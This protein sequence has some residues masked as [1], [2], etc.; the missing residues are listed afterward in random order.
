MPFR[1]TDNCPTTK[2]RL[3]QLKTLHGKIG[4]PIFFPV[5]SQATVKSLSPQELNEIGIEAI[6]CNT[7]HLY[8]RPGIDVIEKAG[9]LHRFMGWEKPILTDSGGY[10][11]FSLA[12][13][14]QI[15]SNGV[16]FRS[17]IDGS[18]HYITPEYAIQLQEKLGADIIMALD[19]CPSSTGK[20]GDLSRA[21]EI[22]TEWA[23]RC[24]RVHGNTG[25]HLFG[26]VQGGV[27]KSLRKTSAEALANFGF[28]GYAIGGLSL[29]EKKSEMWKTVV[30]TVPFLPPDK[31]RYLMGVGSPEDIVEGISRGIDIFDSALPTRVA[32]NGA[33]YTRAGRIN[34]KKSIHRYDMKPIEESCTCFTCRN[35]SIA[36]VHHLFKS[37][38]LLAYR[39]ATIH[40]VFFMN[41]L[42]SEIRESIRAGRFAD[43]KQEFITTYQIT[44]EDRRIA[45]KVR[46]VEAKHK[47]GDQDF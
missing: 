18:E 43:F 24:I 14:R 16:R 25:Q 17:H 10:Q 15:D 46:S 28:P 39:L 35:F 27:D 22:T 6:L 4:T 13:L 38:E 2:A 32:R 19:V 30:T 11:I 8:L 33:L 3:G 42:I 21:V 36:Y 47:K 5:G 44:D 29:G 34:I 31:P 41:S 20:K 12:S 26:I 37:E 7:Y 45:Q 9:G 23:D 1:V 40:N